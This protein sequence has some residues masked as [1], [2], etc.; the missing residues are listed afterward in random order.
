MPPTKLEELGVTFTPGMMGEDLLGAPPHFGIT[1]QG[2]RTQ[3]FASGLAVR[4]NLVANQLVDRWVI[5]SQKANECRA[6]ISWERDVRRGFDESSH[7]PYETNPAWQKFEETSR[8][9]SPVF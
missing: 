3:P 1:T 4:E 8:L 7:N 2:M 9:K 6:L 5:I